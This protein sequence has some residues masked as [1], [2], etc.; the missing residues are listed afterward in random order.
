MK[1]Q[2]APSAERRAG[3]SLRPHG[4]PVLFPMTSDEFCRLPESETVKLELLDGEVVIMPRATP[5]HQ[6]FLL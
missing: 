2:L 6:Y 4:L 1:K 5:L 3:P